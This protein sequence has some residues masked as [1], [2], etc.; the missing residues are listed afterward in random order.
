[1]ANLDKYKNSFLPVFVYDEDSIEGCFVNEVVRYPQE[2]VNRVELCRYPNY[3]EAFSSIIRDGFYYSFNALLFK[4]DKDGNEYVEVGHSHE[5]SFEDVIKR[6]YDSPESFS[7]DRPDL[8]LYS[9]QEILFLKKLKYYLIAIGL[10]DRKRN[11]SLTERAEFIKA[12]DYVNYEF[13]CSDLSPKIACGDIKTV[14]NKYHESYFEEV[15]YKFLFDKDNNYYGIAK[16]NYTKIKL[17]DLS[18]DLI[19]FKA[20]GFNSIS[21]YIQYLL[22]EWNTDYYKINLDDLIICGE[23][24]M[25]TTYKNKHKFINE[26]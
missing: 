25:V 15:A 13:M 12:K 14:V 20:R 11:E 2:K 6:L 24:E 21:E 8:D 10:K 9:K 26:Q 17:C 1:M 4:T 19:D 18:K 16:I 7:I 3:I 5:H 23:V 22:N